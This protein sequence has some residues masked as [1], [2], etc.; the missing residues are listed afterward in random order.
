MDYSLGVLSTL[1]ADSAVR[2]LSISREL[3][4]LGGRGDA[5][6]PPTFAQAKDEEEGPRYV[7]SERRIG[8]ETVNTCLLDSPASQANRIEESLLG[9]V[10][11]GKLSLPL[12][13]MDVPNIG[14]LTDLE[15]PHRIYDAAVGT[16]KLDDGTEWKKSVIAKQVREASRKNASALLEHAPL[17]LVLGGWDSHS[18]T[19]ANA[20][21]GRHEKAVWS[22]IVGVDAFKMNRPGGRLD[23]MGLPPSA[24]VDLGD[25]SKKLSVQGLGVVPPS[26]EKFPRLSITM[27][28]A[29]QRSV[30]SLGV[31]RKIGFGGDGRDEVARSYLAALGILGLAALHRDGGHL[32]SECDLVCERTDGWQ[33]RR[34]DSSDEALSEVTVERALEVVQ[35]ALERF[36]SCALRLRKDPV[37]L[38]VHDNLVAAMGRG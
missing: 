18:G 28:Y 30:I 26:M 25:G 35:S 13:R 7:W 11:A 19:A 6:A 20:W 23:P 33:I 34:D 3:Q 14:V 21:Q 22:K 5:V 2:G 10:R 27:Q 1:M 24:V 12:H 8:V 15:L 32:R 37:N 38:R 9:L 17:I 16:S 36:P 4:P 29:E 31:F